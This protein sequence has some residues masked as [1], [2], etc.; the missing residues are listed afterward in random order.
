V[1]GASTN[2]TGKATAEERRVAAFAIGCVIWAKHIR[3][4]LGWATVRA[5]GDVDDAF[6][7]IEGYE[8][9]LRWEREGEM[10]RCHHEVRSRS[11]AP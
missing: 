1:S 4:L 6:P 5:V 3:G 7:L 9:V 11:D 2:G 10:Y 8:L